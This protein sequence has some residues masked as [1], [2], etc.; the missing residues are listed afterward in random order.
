M[1][2]RFHLNNF[3]NTIVTTVEELA[4]PQTPKNNRSQD[5]FSSLW[6]RIATYRIFAKDKNK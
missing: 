5:A 6:K 3:S 2:S 1:T 4:L